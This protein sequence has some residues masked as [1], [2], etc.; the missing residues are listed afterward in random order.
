MI[1]DFNCTV[2]TNMGEGG[3]KKE[4]ISNDKSQQKNTGSGNPLSK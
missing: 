2:L 1:Y 4:K 3:E